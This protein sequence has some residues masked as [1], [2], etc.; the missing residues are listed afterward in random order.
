VQLI[1][2]CNADLQLS[3]YNGSIS[4]GGVIDISC[5]RLSNDNRIRSL[6]L[7]GHLVLDKADAD[8]EAAKAL[9]NIVSKKEITLD[10]KGREIANAVIRGQMLDYSGYA[11]VNRNF[12]KSARLSGIDIL[13]D[14]VDESHPKLMGKEL[15]EFSSFKRWK[16]RCKTTIDSVV[17]NMS[18][19]KVSKNR[20]LYTTVETSTLP[21]SLRDIV[22]SYDKVWTTSKFCSDVLKS[23]AGMDSEILHG[24]VD[25]NIWT[26]YGS[27][28]VFNPSLKK[29]VFISVFNWGYRKAPDIM[30]HSYFRFFKKSDDVSLLLVSRFKRHS[31]SARGVQDEVS[32]VSKMYSSADIPHVARFSKE[33]DDYEL[34]SM[35][36]ASNAFVLSSRGEGYGLPH[37][38]SLLCGIPVIATNHGGYLDVLDGGN[39]C[40]VDVDGFKKVP[41]GGTGVSYWDGQIM[42]DLSS[43]DF[44]DRF[45]S[46]MRS[47]YENYDH[48]NK[49]TSAARDGVIAK[50]GTRA[51]AAKIQS[52]MEGMS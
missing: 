52:L 3:G 7:S 49:M 5:A 46:A 23:E 34:A 18:L 51:I 44:I 9:M 12:V 25:E 24:M 33:V 10:S 35:Y 48:H 6:V 42:A 32:Q 4:P 40:L 21:L 27:K 30:L 19:P 14:P 8:C 37:I 1:N 28:K 31:H 2:N 43:D 39:S 41:N 50:V 16:G 29:F 13:V 15:V 38:E 36:R 47:V 22:H 20:I 11:K 26:P 17:P 45:G